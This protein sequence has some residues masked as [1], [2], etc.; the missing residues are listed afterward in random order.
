VNDKIGNGEEKR[1][2]FFLTDAPK[3]NSGASLSKKK[4]PEVQ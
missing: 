3:L 1:A 4:D 2:I